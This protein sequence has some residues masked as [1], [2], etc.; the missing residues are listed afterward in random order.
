MRGQCQVMGDS[1]LV[2]LIAGSRSH[3]GRFVLGA[4][5]KCVHNDIH[6]K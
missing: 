2:Q 5:D 1:S 4:V 6:N 3:C